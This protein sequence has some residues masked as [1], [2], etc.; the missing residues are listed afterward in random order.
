MFNLFYIFN[1]DFHLQSAMCNSSVPKFSKEIPWG[2]YV[3][4]MRI[5]IDFGTDGIGMDINDYF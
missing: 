1:H 3:F 4:K 2:Y 5:G